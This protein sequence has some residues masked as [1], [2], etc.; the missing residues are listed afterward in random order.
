MNASSCLR[1]DIFP[2]RSRTF[3]VNQAGTISMFSALM[4][5][6]IL[7]SAALSV[8]VASVYLER[9]TAQSIVDLAAINAANNMAIANE[10]ALATL[11]A[12]EFGNVRKFSLRKGHYHADTRL[13]PEERFVAGAT[14]HNAVEIVVQRPVSLYF[15]KAFFSGKKDLGV[16]SVARVSPLAAFSIG[17]RLAAVRGGLGNQILGAA[18]GTNVSLSAMDYDALASARI[19][20]DGLLRAL[21]DEIHLQAAS[22]SDILASNV[23]LSQFLT[24]AAGELARNGQTGAERI[25]SNL[26]HLTSSTGR[27]SIGALMDAGPLASARVNDTSTGL[28]A[29]VSALDLLQTAALV[30]NGNNQVAFDLD[31]A[32]PNVARLRAELFIGE[33]PVHSSWAAVGSPA[34]TVSTA[35]T[36]LKI[37]AD[38]AG[39]GALAGTM[40]RLPLYVELAPARASLQDVACSDTPSQQQATVAVV[41][42]VG[43]AAIADVASADWTDT[44]PALT[45]AVLV[46]ASLLS[47][48]AYSEIDIRNIEPEELTFSADDIATG[49]VHRAHTRSI[50]GSLVSSLLASADFEVKALGL[51]LR[52][53]VG[54]LRFLL[55]PVAASLDPIVDELL[56]AAGVKLGEAD[57]TVHGVHCATARLAG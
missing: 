38:I 28:S 25:Y 13:K 11:K 42:G 31:V 33:R 30:A 53:S 4:L 39:T 23:T 35:Q 44:S 54:Q 14:P 55:A 22:F 20:M 27:F 40:I 47:V 18:L 21:N 24:S 19:Q 17:S 56:T 8:D 41:T 5:P 43:K 34:A 51:G 46:N 1:L 49:T 10:A 15:A 26:A 2:D 12:N 9:R 16:R 6:I 29:A 37:V 48:S 32:V 57:V 45:P 52:P 36:R 3:L 50:A 7:A